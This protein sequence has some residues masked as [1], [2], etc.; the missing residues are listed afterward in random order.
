MQI[1][2]TGA[3]GFVGSHLLKMLVTAGH[4]VCV[5][6]RSF[7]KTDRM[8]DFI[9]E[10]CVY[11][12]DKMPIEEIFKERRIECIIHCATF[13]GRSDNECIRNIEA[14]LVFPLELLNCGCQH[15]LRYFINTDS[16][17]GNQIQNE[18]DLDGDFYMEGYTLSKT[19]FR[20]WGHIFAKKC[21]IQFV[22]MK[23][24]HVYGEN[25]EPSK[26]IS[27]VEQK[28]RE[29]V[30][31]LELSE[32]TQRRDFV[33][34]SDVVS[35]YRVVL[36]YIEQHQESGYHE[37]NV[38]T[39]KNWSIKEF[40]QIIHRAV[41]SQTELKWGAIGMKKG[42]LMESQADNSELLRIGWKPQVTAEESIERIFRNKE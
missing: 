42:E 37:Y 40:V 13:Y 3:T 2:L 36:E 16:F 39:G 9:D 34:V 27:F 10:C 15:G 6:K 38:G 26:F 1:L 11:D 35:A 18:K 30:P 14:N 4:S 41:R 7:S 23:L 25:D 33:H 20:Q 12:I 17:F 19:Q 24:E 8:V 31:V 21:D 22:N 29:N 32:G 28:C 5:L